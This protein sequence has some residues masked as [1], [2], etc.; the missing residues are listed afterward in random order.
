MN[1]KQQHALEA[2]RGQLT[3][4]KEALRQVILNAVSKSLKTALKR[5]AWFMSNEYFGV[6][7]FSDGIND[8]GKIIE[9]RCYAKLERLFK[10]Q[11]L[12]TEQIAEEFSK[13]Y[14][15]QAFMHY[16]ITKH[17]FQYL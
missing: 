9:G 14:L 5:N 1:T 16:W 3:T 7:V 17:G 15:R 4:E 11:G 10:Q 13:R 8:D 6:G 2:L 12:T